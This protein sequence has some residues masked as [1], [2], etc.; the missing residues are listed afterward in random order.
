MMLL[1]TAYLG[2]VPHSEVTENHD[3]VVTDC[4]VL[5]SLQLPHHLQDGGLGQVL[6]LETQLAWGRKVG[7][8]GYM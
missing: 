3:D 5:R 7:K 6:V 8:R 2:G 1:R 4:G